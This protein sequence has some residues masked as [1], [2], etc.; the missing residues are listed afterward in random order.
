VIDCQKSSLEGI[1]FERMAVR[2]QCSPS[3]VLAV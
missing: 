2:R 1:P 3:P